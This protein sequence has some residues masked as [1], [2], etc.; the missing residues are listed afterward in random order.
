MGINNKLILA[1]SGSLNAYTPSNKHS[2]LKWIKGLFWTYK[3]DTVDDSTRS[4]YYLIK[5]IRILKD[6]YQVKPEELNIQLWG[7]IDPV[8]QKQVISEGLNDYFEFGSYMDKQSSLR[9]LEEATVLFLPLEKSNRKGYRTLFIPGKLFEYIKT[10]KPIL[11]L[12]E[13]SDCRTILE[14][15]GLGICVQPDNPEEIAQTLEKII[16]NRETLETYK[17]QADYISTF[18]FE[19]KTAELAEVFNQLIVK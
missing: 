12:A 1:Y 17:P 8:N 9:K 14:K 11:A 2:Y 13:D 10:G 6:K 16:R 7:S 18:K 4:A 5:A 19:N 3:H 15:S